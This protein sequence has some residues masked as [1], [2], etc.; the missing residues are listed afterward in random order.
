MCGDAACEQCPTD[1]LNLT[2]LSNHVTIGVIGELITHNL[3]MHDRHAVLNRQHGMVVPSAVDWQYMEECPSGNTA[4]PLFLKKTSKFASSKKII[5][6]K[7]F[8]FQLWIG[9]ET[10]W[11]FASTLD[12]NGE[13]IWLDASRCTRVTNPND[14]IS[15]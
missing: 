14:D 4:P 13:R 15:R 8:I 11:L 2:S 1:T 6:I 3:V 5:L 10:R 12:R 7:I 9:V